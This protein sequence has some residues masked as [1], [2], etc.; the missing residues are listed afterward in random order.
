MQHFNISYIEDKRNSDCFLKNNDISSIANYYIKG[1]E[2]NNT[3]RL[4]LFI[5]STTISHK[6]NEDIKKGKYIF[7][8]KWGK[9]IKLCY[10][11][12]D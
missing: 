6:I 5:E 11:V 10:Q 4:Y 8:S 12:N 3:L 7:P 9:H 1:L 2:T